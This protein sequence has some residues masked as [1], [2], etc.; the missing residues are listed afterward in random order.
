MRGAWYGRKAQGYGG[1]FLPPTPYQRRT[2]ATA[3][4]NFAAKFEDAVAVVLSWYG[5]G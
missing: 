2:T 5:V 4:S 3:S 1:D